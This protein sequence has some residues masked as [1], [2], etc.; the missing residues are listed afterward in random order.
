M[1]YRVVT[2]S[3]QV[4][5]GAGSIML[6]LVRNHTGGDGSVELI[7]DIANVPAHHVFTVDAPGGAAA[8]PPVGWAFAERAFYVKNGLWLNVTAVTEV[9]V[10]WM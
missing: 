1:P 9:L 2:G 4:M 7:D 6:F 3:G 5:P 8:Q 10:C